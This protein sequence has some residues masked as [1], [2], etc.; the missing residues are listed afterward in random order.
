MISIIIA[1]YDRPASLKQCLDHVERQSAL[2]LVGEIIIVDDASP[3][4]D[5]RAVVEGHT[6][7]PL[8]RFQRRTVNGG[9]GPARNDAIDIACYPTTLFLD[10]DI[11]LAPGTLAK[12]DESGLP[13]TRKDLSL[14]GHVA[15]DNSTTVTPFMQWMTDG[16]PLFPYARITDHDDCHWCHYVTSLAV[17]STELVKMERFTDRLR[18]RYEDLELG[19]RLQRRHGNR[20]RYVAGATAG[21]LHG[22]GLA[23]WLLALRR[24]EADLVLLS[25]MTGDEMADAFGI[26]RAKALTS[27][28]TRPLRIASS[29]IRTL[30]P[31]MLLPLR[32]DRYYGDLWEWQSLSQ[33]YRIIQNFFRILAIRDALGLAPLTAVDTETDSASF[34]E[35][36]IANLNFPATRAEFG[37]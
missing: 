9:P 11:L 33:S 6:L 34:A 37:A 14:I 16:G 18:C 12:L 21:D 24:I 36:L 4:D 23:E 25:A 22:R 10:D 15:W 32:F 20:L 30:E 35:Q 17:S 19:Y 5:T 29:L 7:H 1:T 27:F 2:A 13:S 8:V 26:I 3:T 28:A 31:Q